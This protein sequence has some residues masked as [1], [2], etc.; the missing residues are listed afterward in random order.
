MQVEPKVSAS[1]IL[2]ATDSTNSSSAMFGGDDA[3][4]DVP[5]EVGLFGAQLRSI[6]DLFEA[7]LLSEISILGVVASLLLICSVS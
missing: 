2:K 4:D 7:C 3:D 1:D 6:R 5:E